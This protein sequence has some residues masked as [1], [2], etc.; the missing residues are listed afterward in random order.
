MKT[1]KTMFDLDFDVSM[2]PGYQS[3]FLSLDRF[4]GGGKINQTTPK[5]ETNL[6]DKR[7]LRSVFKSFQVG[8]LLP[9]HWTRS[10]IRGQK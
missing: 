5:F 1:K 10:A 4:M 8:E 7:D 9:S 3:R 6:A 2:Q